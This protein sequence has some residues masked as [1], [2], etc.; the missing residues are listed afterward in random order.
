MTQPKVKVVMKRRHFGGYRYH[1]CTKCGNED[2]IQKPVEADLLY[3]GGCGMC[4]EDV[5]HKF[6]GWC[7][8]NIEFNA[9]VS[10]E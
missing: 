4:I 10:H 8:V 5:S 3:C 2:T 9:E 7:G 6:C 1:K